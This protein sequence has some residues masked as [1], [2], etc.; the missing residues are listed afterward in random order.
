MKRLLLLTAVAS[1]ALTLLVVWGLGGAVLPTKV[2]LENQRV[3]VSEVTY[4]PGVPRT[5]FTRP[6]DE[7]IIFL[8]DCKY[9]RTDSTTKAK[10]IRTRKSGEILW[11]NKGEDAPQ[12]INLGTTPYRTIVVELK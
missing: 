10:E 4:A 12:L 5:R 9:E 11:H 8:N 3:K 1:S 7:V 2:Q 6:T